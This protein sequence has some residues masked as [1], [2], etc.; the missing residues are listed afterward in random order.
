[1]VVEKRVHDTAAF[2]LFQKKE[3]I[4]AWPYRLSLLDDAGKLGVSI[5]AQKANRGM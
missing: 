3:C 5:E 4:G 1:L 2:A